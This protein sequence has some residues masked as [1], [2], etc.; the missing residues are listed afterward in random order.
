MPEPMWSYG[1]FEACVAHFNANPPIGGQVELDFTAE[2]IQ[3][4]QDQAAHYDCTLDVFLTAV[5]ACFENRASSSREQQGSM[6]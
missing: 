1:K 2:E 6:I 3:H 4:V 5:M